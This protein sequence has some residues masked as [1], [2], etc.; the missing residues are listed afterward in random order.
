MRIAGPTVRGALLLALGAL[1][2]ADPTAR[3]LA[4]NPGWEP[5][6]PAEDMG[7]AE[8][9]AMLHTPPTGEY[10]V[11]VGDVF[12][13]RIEN[14]IWRESSEREVAA[15]P[16]GPETYTVVVGRRSCS[17]WQWMSEED[18]VGYQA[19]ERASWYLLRGD[20]LVAWDH[21]SY[22]ERCV[23]ANSFRPAREEHRYTEKVMLRFVAQRF[24]NPATP[25]PIR[26]ERGHAYLEAERID[27]ARRMLKSGDRAI[28]SVANDHLHREAG[29]T[30]TALRAEED[31][32]RRQRA[33]LSVAIDRAVLEEKGVPNAP[34]D[35]YF[36]GV[37][38]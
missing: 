30:R 17:D 21:W 19:E 18:Y 2:C 37:D 22:G 14:D 24:P 7:A 4:A 8:L 26:F 31:R 34:V 20:A 3:F 23:P 35:R 1:A 10:S 12:V 28:E 29:E 16:G 6:P 15:E 11:D 25:A 13:S 38:D 27:D 9:I 36:R 5:R 32:L 33:K